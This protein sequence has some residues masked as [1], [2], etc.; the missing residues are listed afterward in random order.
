M[1]IHRVAAVVCPSIIAALTCLLLGRCWAADPPAGPTAWYS[2]DSNTL[3]AD[4]TGNAHDATVTGGEKAPGREGSGLTLTGAGGLRVPATDDLRA[5]EGFTIDCWVRFSAVG[6]N[7]NIASKDGEY[8]LRVDPPAEGGSFSFFVE[9]DGQLEPRVNGP[10]AVAGKW[11]HLVAG[12]DGTVASL[13][14]N[15][16]EYV[17]SRRGQMSPGEAPVFIGLPSK[18]GPAGLV[19][20]IDE[21]KLYNR[22]VRREE[23]LITELGL[24]KPV[25]G[26]RSN[27]ARFEFTNDVEGW[28]SVGAR[29]PSV[30][31]GRLHLDV[32][33]EGATLLNRRLAVPLAGKPYV[34]MRMSFTAGPQA[35]LLFLTPQG[36]GTVPF[37]VEADGELHSYVLDLSSG[38]GW[39]DELQAIGLIPPADGEAVV[40]F[41]R[42][43][44]A[45]EAPPEL[46]ADSLLA[47]PVIPRAGRP[48]RVSASVRN[49][50][51][52]GQGLAARLMAPQ[53]VTVVGGP[54]QTIE[55][56]GFSE[57]VE[58]SWDVQADAATEAQLRL[59]LTGTDVTPATRELQ[60]RFLPALTPTKA[61]YVPEPQIAESKYLVGAHYCP[62]W[63]QGARSTGWEL[64]EPYPEREPALGWY[65]EDNPEV[66]DW[67]IKYALE[68]GISYFVYC[69]YRKSQGQAVQMNLSH[70][71]HDGLFHS[72]YGSKFKFA[73][74]WENQAKGS[75]GVASEKDFLENLL[76]FWIDNYFKHPSYLKVDGK[77]L[78]F[79]YRPEYLIGDL[80]GVEQV[81]TALDKARQAC[82]AAGFSGLTI[83]GEDRGVHPGPLEL[84]KSE[85]LDRS[86]SYCWP[87]AQSP[88]P[89]QAI[90]AQEAI[91]QK[92]KQMNVLPDLLTIS[93]GWDSTPWHSSS[94][95]W[96]LPPEDF[97]TLCRSARGFMD[98]LPAG[99][100]AG[101]MVLLDNWNEF[102]EGHYIAPHREYGFGY[103]DAVRN[104][105]CDIPRDHTDLVPEDLGLGP[106][107]SHYRAFKRQMAECAEIRVSEDAEPG[108]IGYWS[109]DEPEGTPYAFDWSG[110]GLG[111]ILDNIGRAPGYRGSALLCN[112]GS[113]T[114]PHAGK[115][116]ALD[117]ITVECWVKTD[118]AGQSDRWFVNN[119]YGS[120]TSGFRLGLSAGRLTW[121]VPKAPWSHHLYADTPLPV[122]EWV[123]VVA[124]Y[125]G[126]ALRLYEN[127]EEC[128]SLQRGGPVYANDMHLCLG[129]YDV[130]HRAFF[131]GLL[132]EVKIHPRALSA[133]EIAERAGR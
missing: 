58:L 5:G 60:V 28:E 3:G 42:V 91:W 2:F 48:V 87:V 36:L 93:M 46:T 133:Q 116:F 82:V 66:T 101:R 21:V 26:P 43:S 19:G 92:R 76:P 45:P 65:D 11:Y 49:S 88:T 107:D 30:A 74:M 99:D 78:L 75:A 96:R 7:M 12:W 127:G 120:G 61:E 41:I 67:E 63:K 23:V 40:D 126:K 59:E 131:S 29:P 115:Q 130:N 98:D 64:I 18:W 121:A 6:Q 106:Y 118:V 56:L 122:G 27:T 25:A 132:D 55:S 17:R 128:A 112:G 86:F 85:G 90:A 89:E 100:L 8:L 35:T 53:D 16:R 113:V 70:A 95:I 123:Y 103:L 10:V 15:G 22:A 97:E 68:H 80:G 104:A 109:F 114:V 125:D 124:T 54:E 79:I 39:R 9:L 52:A 50:G 117:E 4:K 102:G 129:S 20:V 37:A 62:L 14:V 13:W 57:T 81:K 69:W 111:G 47:T 105:F 108:L 1:A 94:T 73:I 51:G 119:L 83:L 84:M 110:H 32:P 24:D 72:R 34:S 38:G 77:P 44:E 71:I 33:E 31:D